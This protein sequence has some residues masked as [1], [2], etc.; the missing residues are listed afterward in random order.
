MKTITHSKSSSKGKTSQ[1]RPIPTPMPRTMPK[2]MSHKVGSAPKHPEQ[3]PH[4]GAMESLISHNE[5][6]M[7]RLK[8][9]LRR[10]S[11]LEEKLN[12]S[13]KAEKKI[14]FHYKNLK[15][16][17]LI[18]KEKERRLR[19]RK[20][21]SESHFHSLSEKVRMLEVEYARLYT[22][23]QKKRISFMETIDGLSHQV[24]RLTK[25]K[26]KLSLVA[27]KL[28]KSLQENQGVIEAL[29]RDLG[30]VRSQLEESTNYI[31]KQGE[32]FKSEREAYER[33]FEEDI[34]KIREELAEAN[35]KA[36]Q[37]DEVYDENVKTQNQLVFL[38]RKYKESRDEFHEEALKLQ[39][40]L[41]HYRSQAKSQSLTIQNYKSE[42]EEKDH[43]IAKLK[44]EASQLKDQFESVQCLWRDNQG[45]IEKQNQKNESLQKLNQ[46]IS[47]QLN[48]YRQDLK[49]L[50]NQL[51]SERQE[52]SQKIQ[53]L[54]TYLQTAQSFAT[55]SPLPEGSPGG[56]SETG[57]GALTNES[58][59][60]KS[61]AIHKAFSPSQIASSL[62]GPL[63][64]EPPS[65]E[66]RPDFL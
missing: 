42:I 53:H 45:H 64:E 32:R 3:P 51:E 52:S 20:E 36:E 34:R 43:L 49:E 37:F 17:I 5:D 16:Q 55:E 2:S 26:T 7:S 24:K 6:L 8:V 11:L 29:K 59:D 40:G 61:E 48:R 30:L 22:S 62:H 41:A 9:T 33:D 60:A 56:A 13:E 28:R 35:K 47:T 57:E 31:Q 50:R 27:H 4:S 21:I 38:Q 25:G 10:V 15:D 63:S 39:E 12:Q 14:T 44:G 23:T 65:P 1:F 66:S 58:T 46:Q 18:L 54:K 19:N